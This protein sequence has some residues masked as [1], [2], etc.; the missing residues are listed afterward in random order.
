MARRRVNN[1]RR[2]SID[3]VYRESRYPDVHPLEV[4]ACSFDIV[5]ASAGNLLADAEVSKPTGVCWKYREYSKR[6]VHAQ[7]YPR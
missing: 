5:T 6:Y 2:Y 4:M 1:L 3:K 7:F